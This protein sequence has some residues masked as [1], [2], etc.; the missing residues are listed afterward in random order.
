ME[1]CGSFSQLERLGV[2]NEFPEESVLSYL[3]FIGFI[4]AGLGVYGPA[5]SL[6]GQNYPDI[7]ENYQQD[8]IPS[9]ISRP[10]HRRG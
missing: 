4:S 9:D 6:F 2:V 1:R 7:G 8:D 3:I 10:Q 5:S